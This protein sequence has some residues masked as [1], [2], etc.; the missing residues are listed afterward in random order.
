[1]LVRSID[2]TENT[3]DVYR[4][5]AGSTDAAIDANIILFLYYV[6]ANDLVIPPITVSAIPPSIP[7]IALPVDISA[8]KS[9]SLSYAY[10]DK[11][12]LF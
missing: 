6:V 10:E 8:A 2:K 9:K 11:A 4:G 12:R 1:M 3:L 5:Y 7:P